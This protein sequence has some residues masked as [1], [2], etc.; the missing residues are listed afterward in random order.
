METVRMDAVGVRGHR[1]GQN[2]RMASPAA[3][4]PTRRTFDDAHAYR[5]GKSRPAHVEDAAGRIRDDEGRFHWHTSLLA[6]A[7]ACTRIRLCLATH[8]AAARSISCPPSSSQ[9][10]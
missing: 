5:G 1:S 2:A 7:P 4:S 9:D 10:G 3:A 6:P 8:R